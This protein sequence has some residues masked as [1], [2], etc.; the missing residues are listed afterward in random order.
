MLVLITAVFGWYAQY[1]K[2]DAS[3]DSLLMEGDTEL[4]FSRQTNNRYG[5]RDTVT[6]AY[7]P[8]VDLFTPEALAQLGALADELR[9]LERVETVN[10][11]LDLPVFGDT[12]LLSISED[13]DTVLTPGLDMAAA[14]EELVQ[15]PVFSN[16]LI[17]P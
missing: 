15:S 5:T 17:S 1:F 7:T 4:E 14:R 2:L 10:S 8:Q 6:I 12:Q 9:T 13:Y 3:A 16:A 11:L